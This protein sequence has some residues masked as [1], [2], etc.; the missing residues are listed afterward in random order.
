VRD[1]QL[2]GADQRYYEALA[3]RKLGQEEAAR[4]RLASLQDT[5]TRALGQTPREADA[6]RG[7]SDREATA[8]YL[9]GLAHIGMGQREQGRLELKRALELRPDLLPAKAALDFLDY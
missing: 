2:D 4:A 3:L 9:A 8:R 5:A 7:T 6:S 1:F